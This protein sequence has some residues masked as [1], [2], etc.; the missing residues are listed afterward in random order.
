MGEES[1]DRTM[2]GELFF[3]TMSINNQ[4]YPYLTDAMKAENN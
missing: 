4:T 2:F 1:S 3:W